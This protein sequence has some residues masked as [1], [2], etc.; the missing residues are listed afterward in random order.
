[1][2]REQNGAKRVVVMNHTFKDYYSNKVKL[3]FAYE[4][5]S[6][7]P[8]HVWVIAKFKDKWL[9]TKHRS[10]GIEFPGGKVEE[11]ETAEDAAVRE[12]MEETGGVV[13]DLHYVAQYFVS[14]KSDTVIKNVYYANI[15]LLT[16][17]ET[18]YE[19]LGPVLLGTIPSNVKTS[20]LYSFMMKDEVL[21]RCLTYVKQ[22]YCK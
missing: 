21:S 1:M 15:E 2:F 17:Q 19:T 12:V 5:F 14:G 18:Y 10:R 11:G 6:S 13:K 22:E 4:P 7:E 3:S 8:K 20:E 9:L 16:E